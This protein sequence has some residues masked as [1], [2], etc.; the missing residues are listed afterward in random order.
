M[1]TVEMPR[2][3]GLTFLEK[4]MHA[5][6]LP[7]VMVSSLTE[8]GCQTTLRA[9]ELGAIDFVTKPKIDVATGT[10]QL[11]EDLQKKVLEAQ[12]ARVRHR[13]RQV[14]P[15]TPAPRSGAL[16][17]STDKVLAIGASTGGTE[18]IRE[19]LMEMPPDAPG[20][21]IVQHMPGGFTRSFAERLNQNC[22]IQVRE[23]RDGDRIL[24]GHAL[25]AP[26]DFHMQV[27]RSGAHYTVR[28]FK[29]PPVNRFRPSVDVLFKSC[30]E[31]LGSHVVAAILTGMGCDRAAGMLAMKQAGAATIAQDASTSVVFGMPKEAIALGGVQET[32]PL[33]KIA[34]RLLARTTS[35]VPA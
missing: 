18:A 3:E 33:E 4:L 31:A 15:R 19:V 5:R 17:Q 8:K 25:L 21:V 27:R 14:A 1:E 24:P 30:A 32:L 20:T 34:S 6:P 9:L 10:V 23:A 11:A 16:L 2:M 35:P 7:V 29:A 28:I 22:Q 12:H 13:G 26:G